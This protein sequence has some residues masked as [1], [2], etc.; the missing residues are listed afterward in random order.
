MEEK[1]QFT[2]SEIKQIAW[3]FWC[4]SYNDTWIGEKINVDD[5]Y[6][7]S[8][9]DYWNEFQNTIEYSVI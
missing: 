3:E 4:E 2:K 9:L 1:Y 6:T 5:D 7:Q 8:F